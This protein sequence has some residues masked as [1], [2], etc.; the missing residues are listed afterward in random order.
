MRLLGRTAAQNA[1]QLPKHG[2]QRFRRPKMQTAGLTA[3]RKRD[4]AV[5]RGITGC[6]ALLLGVPETRFTPLKFRVT[7]DHVVTL[8]FRRGTGLA[9]S[10]RHVVYI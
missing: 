1:R 9:V 6:K 2:A 4:A 7:Q 10:A 8:R 5:V 3:A